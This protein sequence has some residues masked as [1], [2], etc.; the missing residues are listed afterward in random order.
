MQSVINEYITNQHKVDGK[1]LTIKNDGLAH[2]IDNYCKNKKEHSE[3]YIFQDNIDKNIRITKKIINIL[4]DNL[5]DKDVITDDCKNMVNLSLSIDDNLVK[6]AIEKSTKI[7]FKENICKFCMMKFPTNRS[8]YLHEMHH[9][10]KENNRL[11]NEKYKRYLEE[12]ERLTQE[13]IT[14][15]MLLENNQKNNENLNQLLKQLA[16]V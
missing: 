12:K 9:E 7:E 4:L 13:H 15:N 6:Q 14:L 10:K 5:C 1:L 16:E 8:K 2:T 11:F 3:Q